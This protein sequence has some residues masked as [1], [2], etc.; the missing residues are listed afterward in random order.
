MAEYPAL[1]KLYRPILLLA[2]EQ[3][4]KQQE[5]DCSAEFWSEAIDKANGNADFDSNLALNLYKAL[6]LSEYYGDAQRLLDRLIGW[7]QQTAKQ[8]PGDWPQARLSATLAVLYCWAGRLP[9]VFGGAIAMPN[10]LFKKLKSLRPIIPAV[11]GRKGLALMLRGDE[12]AVGLLTQALEAGSQFDEVYEALLEALE[13]DPDALKAIRRKF[14]SRFGDS[15]VDAEVVMPPWVEVLT[16]Q[17]Y[18]AMEQFVREVK[19]PDPA[20][21]ALQIFLDSAADQPSSGQK[22]TLNQEKAVPQWAKLLAAHSP[23]QQ[24]EIVKAVYFVIQQHAKRKQKRSQS[25]SGQLL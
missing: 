15:G 23:E 6:E 22:I 1:E 5:F 8:N 11:L 4:R 18:A 25:A 2:G 13:D 7:L 19:Q 3:A 12:A 17:D 10:E 16:F 20:L 9:D 21:K 24:V 14:G